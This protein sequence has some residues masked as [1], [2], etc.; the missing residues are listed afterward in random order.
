MNF[1]CRCVRA[2]RIYLA[3]ILNFLHSFK[4]SEIVPVPSETKKDISWWRDFAQLFNGVSLMPENFWSAPDALLATDSC[5]T[6]GGAYTAQWFMHF[7]FPQR[8]LNLCSHINQLECIVLVV[9]LTRW[10]HLFRRK[11]LQINCDNQV[12]VIAINSG[13]SRNRIIQ[14][15][16]RYMHKIAGLESVQVRAVYLS[17]Q[18]NRA[19]DIL[20]RWHLDAKSRQHFFSMMGNQ[21]MEV[22]I[23]HSDFEF[24]F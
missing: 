19:T 4:G 5:L 12:M 7:V 18:Q 20:S 3:R 23:G 14:K 8:V 16:L 17:S 9:T 1:A 13:A 2:G 6:G 15:C 10:V 22:Q 11:N 21:M 24:L